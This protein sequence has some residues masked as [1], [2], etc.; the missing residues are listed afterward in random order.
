MLPGRSDRP[1]RPTGTTDVSPYSAAIPVTIS[2][3]TDMTSRHVNTVACT[4]P[5]STSHWTQPHAFPLQLRPRRPCPIPPLSPSYCL[6]P[7]MTL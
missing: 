7:R 6:L 3:D 5:R 1:A 4:S 2:P